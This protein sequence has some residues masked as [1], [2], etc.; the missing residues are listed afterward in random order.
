[1]SYKLRTYECPECEKHFEYFHTV[2]DGVEDSPPDYCPKC[3]AFVGPDQQP[4]PWFGK[5]GKIQNQTYDKVYRGMEAAS[6]AR[7]Q[8][9]ADMLGV[10]VHE[11]SNIKMDN[12]RD[13]LREGDI[14]YIGPS[15]PTA[16][17][18]AAPPTGPANPMA[19]QMGLAT[20]QMVKSQGGSAGHAAMDKLKAGH[21]QRAAQMARAGEIG[22]AS[23]KE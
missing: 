7:A 6:H 3:G 19:G 16:T 11:M 13:N 15:A 21:T 4:L 12:M 18:V 17:R 1:M 9:A 20:A 10:P 14:S 8:E 2:T 23:G 22:R 5:I